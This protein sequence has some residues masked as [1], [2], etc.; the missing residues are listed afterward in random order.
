M[1]FFEKTQREPL[2]AEQI[3]TT[4]DVAELLK[5]TAIRVRQLKDQDDLDRPGMKRLNG[6]LHGGKWHFMGS[7]VLR[8]MS[9]PR[10]NGRPGGNGSM[11]HRRNRALKQPYQ[12]RDR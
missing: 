7:E 3:L 5:V 11:R 9:I 4:N 10:P 12:K 8:F 1:L 2:R 6:F